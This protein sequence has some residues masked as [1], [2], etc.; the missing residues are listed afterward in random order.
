[1]KSVPPSSQPDPGDH[2]LKIKQGFGAHAATVPCPSCGQPAPEGAALCPHCGRSIAGRH[3]A[4]L[5]VQRHPGM[6]FPR[7]GTRRLL[8]LL[9]LAGT[10]YAFREP[11]LDAWNNLHEG[12][13]RMSATAKP[14]VLDARCAACQGAGTRTCAACG[15]RGTVSA[16]TAQPCT[17][18]GGSGQ[19]RKRTAK[20]SVSC[21]FCH[22]SGQRVSSGFATCAACGG[23]GHVACAACGGRGRTAVTNAPVSRGIFGDLIGR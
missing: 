16:T 8:V 13:R 11:L 12:V 14:S 20:S 10:G 4:P 17:Q 18:C 22:G 21:P 7:R 9:L 23:Q 1:M 19:Y 6:V 5:P 3:A 15:A 2:K